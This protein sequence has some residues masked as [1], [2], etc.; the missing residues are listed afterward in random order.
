MNL[1]SAV[2]LQIRAT[3]TANGGAS[4][5]TDGPFTQSSSGT[6]A[7]RNV[8]LNWNDRPASV[9][10]TLTGTYTENG[11]AKTVTA[12]TNG[13]LCMRPSCRNNLLRNVIIRP[14]RK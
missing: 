13:R 7:A 5:G 1:N 3:V 10:L 12:V 14:S 2:N 8:A 9:T 6:S 11:T 4:L